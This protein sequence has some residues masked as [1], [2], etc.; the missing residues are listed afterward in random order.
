MPV[1]ARQ[2]VEVV[3]PVGYSFIKINRIF[4]IIFQLAP[5]VP[6]LE[7]FTYHWKMMLKF[8]MKMDAAN[9]TIIEST[10]IP[11][12]LDQ[13]FKVGWKTLAPVSPKFLFLGD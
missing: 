5:P 9:K 12:H 8:Y 1:V 4:C 2:T 6:Q 3:I 7:D 13:M 11:A 10:N